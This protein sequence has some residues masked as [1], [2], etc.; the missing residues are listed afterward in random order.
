MMFPTTG[1][2]VSGQQMRR[3]DQVLYFMI[4]PGPEAAAAMDGLRREHDLARKYAAERFHITL[5]PFG[6]IRL[7][8]PENLNRI[9]QAAASLRA[10]PF[11]VALNR[12]RGN[13][14]VGNRMRALRDFQ[15]ALVARIDAFGIER[16]DYAFNP[17]ASLSYEVPQQRNISVPPIAWRVEEVLLINSVHG[18]GHDLLDSWTLE[19]RQGSLPF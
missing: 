4:K 15:R 18:K 3:D 11:D 2:A 9:R 13:A 17:H 16:P 10:D 14:L 6:D 19:P 7:L 1:G 12:I 5:V 8:S